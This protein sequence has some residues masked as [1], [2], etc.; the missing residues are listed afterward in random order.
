MKLSNRKLPLLDTLVP[1][2]TLVIAIT[3]AASPA[4]G[5]GNAAGADVYKAKCATCHGQDGS[6]NTPVGKSLQVADL[7]SAAVQS[8]S[9][10]ELIQS[11]TEGKGNM[12]GFKGNITDDEIHAVVTFIRTFAGKGDSAPKKK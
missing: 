4:A 5:Q 2:A 8:K 1:V 6:G 10:A 9:D 12:P 11:V 7:R 3:T